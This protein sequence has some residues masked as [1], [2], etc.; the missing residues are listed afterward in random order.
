MSNAQRPEN[1]LM[2]EK[3]MLFSDYH[4]PY[5]FLTQEKEKPD[6]SVESLYGSTA[7]SKPESYRATTPSRKKRSYSPRHRK[8][9]NSPKSRDFVHAISSLSS[10]NG[11]KTPPKVHPF[12]DNLGSD[13]LTNKTLKSRSRKS[14]NDIVPSNLTET[15]SMEWDP[16]LEQQQR[17]KQLREKAQKKRNFSPIDE[18]EEPTKPNSGVKQ[19]VF[20]LD[21]SMSSDASNPDSGA[22]SAGNGTE[23]K[24]KQ[25][26]TE[27]SD[28]SP[29]AQRR[30][31]PNDKRNIKRIKDQSPILK[32]GLSINKTP[33]IQERFS[34]DESSP[35]D[36]KF[37]HERRPRHPSSLSSDES[38]PAQRRHTGESPTGMLKKSSLHHLPPRQ[39]RLLSDDSPL[40][41]SNERTFEPMQGTDYLTSNTQKTPTYKQIN[42]FQNRTVAGPSNDPRY[43]RTNR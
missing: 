3:A 16:Y 31:Q 5:H 30:H 43:I 1:S 7:D 18:E 26:G 39:R 17:K 28:N 9:K 12:K 14:E 23:S 15:T 20:A 19:Q 8:D 25:S 21:S 10:M 4:Q 11:D 24:G 36:G 6:T 32:K 2:K 33:L 27:S 22:N 13:H 29:P 41:K 38:P 37:S 34:D 35:S 40:N 42:E